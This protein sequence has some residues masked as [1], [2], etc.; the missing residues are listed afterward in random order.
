ME[1]LGGSLQD[2]LSLTSFAHALAIWLWSLV[3]G[4]TSCVTVATQQF[5]V[6]AYIC[7]ETQP[8]KMLGLCMPV[9]T[10]LHF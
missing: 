6:P 3:P 4:S 5:Q 2:S 7:P 10:H 1:S 8:V 9:P